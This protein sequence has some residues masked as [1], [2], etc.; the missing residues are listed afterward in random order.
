MNL[1]KLKDQKGITGVDITI[2]ISI[3]SITT[4]AIMAIYLNIIVGSKKVTRTSAA[5]RIATSILENID[6]MYYAE[7]EHELVRLSNLPEAI[8]GNFSTTATYDL[9][10]SSDIQENVFNTKLNPGYDVEL[11]VNEITQPSNMNNNENL[12]IDIADCP[13]VL[14]IKVI[15]KYKVSNREEE[16]SLKTVKKRE[17]LQECNEPNINDLLGQDFDIIVTNNAGS[18]S[19]EK[20]KIESLNQVEPIKWSTDTNTY[21]RTNKTN[22]WYSYINKE[23]ARVVITG[24]SLGEN[25]VKAVFDTSSDSV[26][27]LPNQ[28]VFVWMPRFGLATTADQTTAFAHGSSNYRILDFTMSV[29]R[30]SIGG[31]M[32]FRYSGV[33][34][35]NKTVDA[36]GKVTST[37]LGKEVLGIESKIFPKGSTGVWLDITG[38]ELGGVFN[39]DDSEKIQF[40]ETVEEYLDKTINKSIFG[41][42][43]THVGKSQNKYY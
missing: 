42:P 11:V 23:W 37:L 30:N 8:Q 32:D 31:V 7:V 10:L 5:T 19:V 13:L 24:V 39:R 27:E 15:V 1:S 2:A 12:Y 9:Y 26:L 28:T 33:V 34:T 41:P 43:V 4:V 29:K 16:L 3:I 25:T 36:E 17:L 40:Y 18:Q 22:N 14:D 21:I 35:C 38:G 6:S 20:R